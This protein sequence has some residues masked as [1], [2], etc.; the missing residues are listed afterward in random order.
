[1]EEIRKPSKGEELIQSL[2]D[3]IN[4]QDVSTNVPDKSDAQDAPNE[5]Q[6]EDNKDYT[7]FVRDGVEVV[8]VKVVPKE[9]LEVDKFGIPIRGPRKTWDKI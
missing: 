9:K 1:V 6:K 4:I 2:Q 3:R 7:G 8:D 5:P